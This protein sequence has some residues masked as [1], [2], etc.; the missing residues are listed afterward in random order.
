MING[1]DFCVRHT[2]T[3]HA[4]HTHHKHVALY[5]K[6]PRSVTLSC[7]WTSNSTTAQTGAPLIQPVALQ[8]IPKGTKRPQLELGLEYDIYQRVISGDTVVNCDGSQSK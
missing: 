4:L 5:C 1:Q 3:H 8:C 7:M 6:W 2:H